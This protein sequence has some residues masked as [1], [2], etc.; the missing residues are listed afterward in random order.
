[1]PTPTFRATVSAMVL[2]VWSS[3]LGRGKDWTARLL[4]SAA[5]RFKAFWTAAV[6]S[7]GVK[8]LATK[9]MAPRF[10][11]SVARSTEGKP[12]IISTAASGALLS[13]ISTT[14]RPF[15]SGM[16]Q[17]HRITSKRESEASSSPWRGLSVVTTS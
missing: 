14:S 11:T 5:L 15:N 13:S 9:S 10:M 17:S 3:R 1:M 12:V 2:G 6:I 8:G 16:R 4:A 7:S